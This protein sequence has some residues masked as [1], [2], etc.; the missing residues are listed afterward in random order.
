MAL[1]Y[2]EYQIDISAAEL[3]PAVNDQRDQMSFEELGAQVRQLGRC[4]AVGVLAV[5]PRQGG[6]PAQLTHHGLADLSGAM[7]CGLGEPATSS[8][9]QV[10]QP[11]PC[12]T[13]S[14]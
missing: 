9:A 3:D 2:G 10:L 11:L 5:I 14:F 8:L 13:C 7:T 12:P 1:R 6:E 4:P